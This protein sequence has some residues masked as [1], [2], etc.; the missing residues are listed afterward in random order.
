VSSLF[1]S[2]STVFGNCSP[3]QLNCSLLNSVVLSSTA[4]RSIQKLSN[5]RNQ[6]PL[7]PI[8][9]IKNHPVCQRKYF[10][11]FLSAKI[12]YL[13]AKIIRAVTKNLILH[14][15][16]PFFFPGS[17][18]TKIFLLPSFYPYQYPLPPTT[19]S[20]TYNNLPRYLQ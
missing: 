12:S 5:V 9:T 20:R 8:N 3:R 16:Y 4:E 2:H 13:S 15:S 10:F 7:L 1:G 6:L 18:L 11:F 19:L 17:S 14:P